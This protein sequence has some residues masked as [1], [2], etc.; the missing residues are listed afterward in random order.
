V[1]IRTARSH[2][3]ANSAM[4]ESAQSLHTVIGAI[5]DEHEILQLDMVSDCIF[6]NRVRMR[7]RVSGFN[8][9][10]YLV[11]ETKRRGIGSLSFDETVEI[12]DLLSFAMVFAQTEGPL[13]QPFQEFARQMQM[14]GISGVLVKPTDQTPDQA[15]HDHQAAPTKEEAKRS[16]FSALHIVKEA[17]QE[18][19]AKG[20][21]NPR[22]VKRVVE[23]VV[24]SILSDEESM[25]ALTAIRDYDEYTYHH[26][27]NVCIYSI[28]LGNRL[29]LP[30]QALCEIGIAALFHDVGKTDVPHDI[31][32]KLENLT[33]ADWTTIQEHT[34]SGVKVLT[35]L[36]KM[37]RAILRSIIVAFCHHLNTD[38]SGYPKTRTPVRPDAFSRIVRIADVYDA[39]TSGRSYRMRPFTRSEALAIITEKAGKELD[40]TMCAIFTD[41]IGEMPENGAAPACLGGLA[42]PHADQ[43]TAVAGP[44]GR[45]DRPAGSRHSETARYYDN[46]DDADDKFQVGQSG[47]K[48][49]PLDAC[50]DRES[51]RQ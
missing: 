38:Q 14:E 48:P 6:F 25:M 44:E 36:R 5:L 12:D 27:F 31:L 24:D 16:F 35:Y 33:E 50:I 41:V 3:R 20:K 28:A 8:T 32:N 26:S 37:D 4:L 13:A 15:T 34:M 23:S 1:L 7:P 22:K 17:V 18:G 42:E 40:P 47:T 46:T 45:E 19:V 21:V 39:L 51:H 10:K 49:G 11:Y 2:D 43:D 30:K 9:I 29:G